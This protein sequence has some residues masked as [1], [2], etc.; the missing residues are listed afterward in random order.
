MTM[1]S[2]DYAIQIIPDLTID[3][4]YSAVIGETQARVDSFTAK[5]LRD[6]RIHELFILEKSKLDSP[7]AA[8]ILKG[9]GRLSVGF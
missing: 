2:S 1:N 3:D 7:T 6:G 9:D 4:R 8:K 5:A